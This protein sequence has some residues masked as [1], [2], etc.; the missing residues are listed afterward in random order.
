[1]ATRTKLS[2]KKRT[3]PRPAKAAAPKRRVVAAKPP[4]RIKKAVKAPVRARTPVKAA[5]KRQP[6]KAAPRKQT[7]QDWARAARK[8]AT[9]EPPPAPAILTPPFGYDPANWPPLMQVSV[10]CSNKRTGYVGILPIGQSTFLDMVENGQIPPGIK[11]GERVTAWPKDVIAKIAR[12]GV[13]RPRRPLAPVI[14]QPA[15]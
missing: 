4:P 7:I 8:P 10:I 9:P 13:P 11:I 1:M 5:P 2:S 15:E 3:P 6:V 14:Q 12:E